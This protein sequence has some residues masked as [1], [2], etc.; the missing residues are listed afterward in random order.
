M[1]SLF[2]L[3]LRRLIKEAEI[4]YLEL[5]FFKKL[6][7]KFRK[8]IEEEMLRTFKRRIFMGVCFFDKLFKSDR[9]FTQ[10]ILDKAHSLS[11]YIIPNSYRNIQIITLPFSIIRF[12]EKVFKKLGCKVKIFSKKEYND[13]FR[14]IFERLE[15]EARSCDE[16]FVCFY[17][18]NFFKKYNVFFERES[19]EKRFLWIDWYLEE[20]FN[21]GEYR[22]EFF[23]PKV[24]Y[25]TEKGYKNFYYEFNESYLKKGIKNLMDKLFMKSNEEWGDV[26]RRFK[27]RYEVPRRFSNVE[28]KAFIYNITS[29]FVDEYSETNKF[30]EPLIDTE[31]EDIVKISDKA[32]KFIND[33]LISLKDF[34]IKMNNGNIVKYIFQNNKLREKIAKLVLEYCREKKNEK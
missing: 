24:D 22:V 20:S 25:T 23:F 17:F 32:R 9:N 6:M 5:L 12:I 7:E 2:N 13:I 31:R 15:K 34:L 3:K 27:I 4:D 10:E 33:F 21:E 30:F 29:F 19:K 16:S 14:N 8:E 18:S 11:L 1:K 26:L 28:I